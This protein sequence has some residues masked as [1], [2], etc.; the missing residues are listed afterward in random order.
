MLTEGR[1][2]ARSRFHP[3][4]EGERGIGDRRGC[5]PP[6]FPS[7]YPLWQSGRPWEV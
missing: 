1:A 5:L 2:P 6:C 7:Q 4:D 3:A